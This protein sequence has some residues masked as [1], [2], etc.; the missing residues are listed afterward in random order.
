MLVSPI[1]NLLS[2]Y[3]GL[4]IDQELTHGETYACETFQNKPLTFKEGGGKFF[5]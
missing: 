5:I 1:Y 4:F 3:Y 2:P